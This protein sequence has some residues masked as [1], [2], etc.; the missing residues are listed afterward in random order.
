M[1]EKYDVIVVG[2]GPGGYVAAIRCAQLGLKTAC[3]EKG[4][5]GGTCL[6]IGCI[7][8]KALLHSS[9]LY[10]QVE[11]HFPEHGVQAG[12]L[13]FDFDKMMERKR[14][15]V[16]G[17]TQGVGTLFQKNKVTH[18]KGTGVLKSANTVSVDGAEFQ[19]SSIILATG[20]EP[21]RLPFLSIDEKRVV[22]S[23]GALALES[24]PQKMIV[25]GAG[26]IG[27]EL[28]S[29]YSRL[30]S[31][32]TFIEF[33][34][35]ICATMDEAI[36][37]AFQQVLEKQGMSFHLSSKVTAADTTSQMI[38][39]TVEKEGEKSQ[40]EANVVLCAIGRRPYS[41][42]LGLEN[43]GIS[44]N[45]RGF[46]PI[47]GRFQTNVP[48][49]YAI[50]DIVEGPMLAHKAMEEGVAVAE[51]IAGKQPEIDY[52]AIPNVVYTDPEVAAVGLT[53]AEAKN[54]GLTV[55]TGSFPFRINSRA[56]CTGEIEGMV[57]IVADGASDRI[58]GM[59]ILG[60]HASE[61]IAEGVVAIENK[62]TALELGNTVHAHPTF[63]E[64]VKE[65]ALAVHGRP[66][67]R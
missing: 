7:P 26:A 8:S 41:T 40:F 13:S 52:I 27:V 54:F 10:Y 1:S 65:A 59:H 42:N 32:V 61:I 33:L 35:R 62:M 43:V 60:A 38:K 19:A 37:R 28:G 45:E 11:H 25:I 36:S 44:L 4:E 57:K 58:L 14:V 30:G 6:N 20:S 67:H 5:L 49:I 51:L 3:V 39:L 18:L 34:P 56:K 9:E 22:T 31:Q 23:T 12:H 15:V 16:K 24:V 47:N 53:E 48:N 46:V 55:K 17:F 2:S 64:A 29:V 66:I 21:I 50:G 63:T